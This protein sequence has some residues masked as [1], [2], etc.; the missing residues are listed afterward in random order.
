MYCSVVPLCYWLSESSWSFWRVWRAA[1]MT[2]IGCIVLNCLIPMYCSVVPIYATGFQDHHGHF[3]ESGGHRPQAGPAEAKDWGQAG[4]VGLWS[5][6]WVGATTVIF[7]FS[8]TRITDCIC[9]DK[10][11]RAINTYEQSILCQTGSTAVSLTGLLCV[12]KA[13]ML[14]MISC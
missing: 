13:Q 3:G 14:N 8:F 1:L 6:W 7:V 12:T 9:S 11:N 5:L 4:K 2:L 10:N